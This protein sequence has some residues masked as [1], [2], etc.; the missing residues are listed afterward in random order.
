MIL[1]EISPNNL[2]KL[3]SVTY[4]RRMVLRTY[5]SFNPLSVVHEFLIFTKSK[6]NSIL[7]IVE[8]EYYKLIYKTYFNNNPDIAVNVKTISECVE[9]EPITYD[10]G[11]IDCTGELYEILTMAKLEHITF[12]RYLVIDNTRKL[13]NID[14]ELPDE[15]INFELQ[16]YKLS[17]SEEDRFI[18]YNEFIIDKFRLFKGLARHFDESLNI[19]VT[20]FDIMRYCIYGLNYS[21]KQ[22]T[23]NEICKLIAEEEGWTSNLQPTTINNKTIIE[24]FHPDAL[25]ESAKRLQSYMKYRTDMLN[26]NNSLFNLISEFAN[27]YNN[28][29]TLV[30]VDT[31]KLAEFISNQLNT[32]WFDGYPMILAVGNTLTS[33]LMYNFITDSVIVDKKGNPKK[34]G[35]TNLIR[36]IHDASINNHC[37][38]YIAGKTIKTVNVPPN[39]NRL[40][41]TIVEPQLIGKFEKSSDIDAIL[42]GVETENGLSDLKGYRWIVPSFIS[43]PDSEVVLPK[44][45]SDVIKMASD[46]ACKRPY[47]LNSYV[48]N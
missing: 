45:L 20:P 30:I 1:N 4:N 13:K 31:T 5:N 46:S 24:N 16:L 44:P 6:T 48:I 8:N 39:I 14:V 10:F 43:V 42:N 7:I 29:Q 38:L 28:Y 25:H 2:L 34:L 19:P 9:L 11:I 21:G 15:D 35:T 36:A 47:L 3:W 27:H 23:Y 12:T 22:F 37:K 41:M 17:D 26:A 18:K 40:C 32:E 33:K